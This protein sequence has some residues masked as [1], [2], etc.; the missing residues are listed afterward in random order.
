MRYI[1]MCALLFA[2]CSSGSSGPTPEDS[3]GS[4][5]PT[6][7]ERH[8]TACAIYEKEFKQLAVI[9]AEHRAAVSKITEEV[10]LDMTGTNQR[11]IDTLTSNAK[12]YHRRGSYKQFTPTANEAME[13]IKKRERFYKKA[14]LPD[15][16][17]FRKVKSLSDSL[18]TT[19]LVP[20]QERRL[21][22]AAATMKEADKAINP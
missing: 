2:S 14:M 21:A 5:G 13:D 22:R 9:K 20:Q 10:C 6:P 15:T 7:E 17:E 18:K 16:D 4:S 12:E 19:I 3:S 8:L 11:I 1:L